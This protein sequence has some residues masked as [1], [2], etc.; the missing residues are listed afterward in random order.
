MAHHEREPVNKVDVEARGGGGQQRAAAAAGERMWLTWSCLAMAARVVAMGVVGAAVLV[1]WAVVFH[2][3][4]AQVA[5][6]GAHWPR[7]S[8]HPARRL[9][10]PLCLR[11]VPPTQQPPYRPGSG[12]AALRRER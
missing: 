10:L 7:P 3:A 4:H 12:P 6:D 2:P 8:R 5:V 11:R 1:W 9:T